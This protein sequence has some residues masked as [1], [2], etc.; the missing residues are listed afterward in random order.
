MRSKEI[1][2]RTENFTS[3]VQAR[4]DI[5]RETP[6][7]KISFMERFNFSQVCIFSAGTLQKICWM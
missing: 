5:K 6:V 4:M 1:I 3:G 2:C 7:C